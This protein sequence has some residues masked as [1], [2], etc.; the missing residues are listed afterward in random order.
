ME[1][2]HMATV[3]ELIE[4]LRDFRTRYAAK[5][6][7][8]EMGAAAVPPLIQAVDS[9][10]PSVRWA[11]VAMLGEIGARQA[12]PRLV[13]AVRDETIRTAAVEALQHISQQDFGADYDAWK[14]WLDMG[15]GAADAAQLEVHAQADGDLI[16][17]AVY[18]TDVSAEGHSRGYVLRV[19]LG[20]RHQDVFINFKAR[21][22]EGA[23]LVVIYTRC[24]PANAKHYEWALRQNVHMSAGAIAVADIEGKPEF[25]VVD[26]LARTIVT[27]GLMIE[28]VR[29]VARKGDQLESALTKADRL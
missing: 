9:R 4:R 20:D 10:N 15:Q 18:G 28:S 8:L 5:N 11:A 14:R 12:V 16:R 22:S 1:G 23:A 6:E 27:P 2:A 25:V 21:D 3:E 17:E 19:P 7:L 29:R 24:G 13:E 26:V